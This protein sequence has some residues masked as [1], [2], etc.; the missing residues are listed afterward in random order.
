MVVHSS[1]ECREN[2]REHIGWAQ[3]A[4]TDRERE[5]LL[6]MARAW[7]DAA[8]RLD[9]AYAIADAAIEIQNPEK[10]PRATA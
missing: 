2:E 5:L 4:R 6:Q 10:P 3:T 7:M 9:A 8:E 1:Q